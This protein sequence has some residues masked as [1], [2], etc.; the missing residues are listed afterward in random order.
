MASQQISGITATDGAKV[1]AGTNT[2]NNFNIGEQSKGDYFPDDSLLILIGN[3]QD[4]LPCAL[5]A[6]S[7]AYGRQNDDSCL[8]GTRIEVLD[9]IREWLCGNDQRHIF[10]LAGWAGTGK[11][12]IVR[13]VAREVYDDDHWMASFFFD[14]GGGHISHSERFVS[15]IAQQLANQQRG[16]RTVLQEVI[17]KDQGIVQR[18]LTDQWKEL[19]A[20]LNIHL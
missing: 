11:S 15:T 13:T 10:W 1:F 8:P 18:A 4:L 5:Q 12:T 17:S 19:I 6:P 20:G 16:F 7:N 14:R 9:S 2:T 3:A